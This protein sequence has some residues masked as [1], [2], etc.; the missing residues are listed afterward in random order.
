MGIEYNHYQGFLRF[1]ETE[2]GIL[3]A[4]IRPKANLLVLLAE[5]FADR[6]P[7]ERWFILDTGRG[8]AAAHEPGKGFVLYTGL[9]ITRQEIGEIRDAEEDFAGMWRTFCTSIAIESR[10]NPGL[11]R[12]N[13]A[14]HFREYMDEFHKV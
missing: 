4:P 8:T 1:R 9:D 2:K 10:R 7:R 5:H 13:L 14:L 3:F 12:Q 6:F 11:Q